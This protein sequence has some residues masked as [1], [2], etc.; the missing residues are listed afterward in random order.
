VLE[1]CPCQSGPACVEAA[2]RAFSPACKAAI[3][4]VGCENAYWFDAVAKVNIRNLYAHVLNDCAGG[5]KASC[6]ADVRPAFTMLTASI[7]CS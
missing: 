4:K 1:G 5:E 3:I 7:A 2:K 6:P